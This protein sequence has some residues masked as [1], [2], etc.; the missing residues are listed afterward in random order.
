MN[1]RER[2][3]AITPGGAQTRSKRRTAFPPDFPEFLMSGEGAR[4]R[5]VR[6][7]NYIDWICGLGSISLGYQYPAVEDAVRRQLTQGV[8]FSLPTTME[9]TV[10]EQLAEAVGAEQVRFVKTGSEANEGACRIARLAT[11]RSIIVSIGYHG[12][13][14][15]QDAA[16]PTHPGVPDALSDYVIGHPWG[17]A[18]PAALRLR[19]TD[20]SGQVAAV[21]VE[22]VRDNEPPP[23]WLTGLRLWCDRRGALLIFDDVVTGFRW[24]VNGT[25]QYLGTRAD[26]RT[27]GKGMANGFPL[28]AIVGSRDVMQHAAYVSGTFG[29]E[30]VSLA[31]AAATMRIFKDYPVIRH[32]WQTGQA[33]MDGFNKLRGPVK[34]E[35]YAVHPRI[36]GD[37]RDVF[38]AAVAREG[39]LFHPAGFNI[40]YSHR[41]AELKDTL[42]ACERV[43]ARL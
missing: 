13:H 19:G 43:M 10:A 40:S 4:V 28:A 3:D 32:M 11:G 29:G 23:G 31:A 1:W 18:I 25:T 38:V 41:E 39:V 21:I 16:S 24:A 14:T 20:V 33:L 30:A 9:V 22:A 37:K 17:T 42:A 7:R 36:T 26:L 12:W 5:D 6:G 2:A 8:S 34:M 27:F 15:L 35:G